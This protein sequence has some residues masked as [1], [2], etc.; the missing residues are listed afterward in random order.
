MLEKLKIQS[1][2]YAKEKNNEVLQLNNDIK[3]YEKKIEEKNNEL[4]LLQSSVE[5]N[6]SETSSKTM[7]FERIISV[8]DNLYQRSMKKKQK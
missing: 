4:N 2:T 3:D 6:S 7:N 5:A 1:A 8:I